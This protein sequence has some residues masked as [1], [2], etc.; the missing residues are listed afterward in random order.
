MFKLLLA[1]LV[2]LILAGCGGRSDSNTSQVDPPDEIEGPEGDNPAGDS[3][4]DVLSIY[5]ESLVP[6]NDPIPV[7]LLS[8]GTFDSA[9]ADGTTDWSFCGASIE[10]ET[11]RG[12]Y[13]RLD[14][15]SIC[16]EAQGFELFDNNSVVYHP[17]NLQNLPETVYLTFLARTSAPIELFGSPLD[18]YLSASAD[19]LDVLFLP[20]IRLST[21]T[22]NSLSNGW[23]RVK[24]QLSKSE[25]E[26]E[27]GDL[28]P[29]WI[30]FDMQNS[31][32]Q[33]DID[34][35]HISQDEYRITQASP[36]PDALMGNTDD[37]LLF[38]N[39][40]A[41]HIG[42]SLPNGK[43]YV[44]YPIR[45]ESL[46]MAPKW[47]DQ[48]T[49]TYGEIVFYPAVSTDPL[50]LPAEGTD[51]WFYDID[52][53]QR[54][55]LYQSIGSPGFFGAETLDA[56]DV[57]VRNGA[58]DTQMDRGA[59]AVCG[60]NR[61]VFV[62]DDV[63]SIYIMDSSGNVLN[64]DTA[65]YNPVWSSTGRLAFVSGND[66]RIADV[67]TTGV[68]SSEV[69]F[70]G[71]SPSAVAWSPGGDQLAI[72]SQGAGEIFVNDELRFIDTIKILDLP[73]GIL[74]EVALIDHGVA[75]PTMGWTKDG[76]F[77][78]YSVLLADSLKS[79]LWWLDIA[80]GGTG[81]ITNTINAAGVS[82]R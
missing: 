21:A 32:Y 2:S 30:Y 36:M 3:D 9:T 64:N 73:S 51:L 16:R 67:L 14:G 63:C 54:S 27:L 44:E 28:S 31:A 12:N 13:L 6:A 1:G 77:I 19:G 4:P 59:F 46:R 80:T 75:Y 52:R 35:V 60:R 61:A 41:Q 69:V 49:F 34:D 33:I 82:L 43:Q 20:A 26:A 58:W 81:P 71:V 76:K 42:S 50:V 57:T 17:V 78:V 62:S 74:S 23:S 56:L 47:F 68:I 22:F 5:Y 24:L 65:G 72:L 11:E 45:T 37:H 18:I 48:N 53:D 10:N 55:L 39:L 15:N 38:M 79:Q 70:F 40:D 29:G 7:N 66:V 8:E 25:I